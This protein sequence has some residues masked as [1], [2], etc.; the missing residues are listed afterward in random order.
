MEI[1]KIKLNNFRNYTNVE[2]FPSSGTNIFY[3]ENGSGKTNIIEAIY[4]T[5]MTKSFR[6]SEDSF[7]VLENT[8]KIT[9]ELEINFNG[10]HKNISS[11]FLKS[12]KKRI[13]KINNNK[14]KRIS[15]IIGTVPI[16]IFSPESIQMLKSDP[17]SRR[18]F[19]DELLFILNNGYY[20]LIQKY[21][22]IIAHR[23]YL[24]K[25]IKEGKQNR[26]ILEPW[27]LQMIEYGSQIIINRYKII[28][29]LNTTIKNE[30]PEKFN[31]IKLNYIAKFFNEFT[32]DSVKNTF[33]NQIDK[34]INEEIVRSVSLIGPHRDDMDVLF[35]NK[36]AKFYASE[37]Q[38]RII[39]LMLKFAEAILLKK[40]NNNSPIILLDDFS[41]E[42][43]ENNRIN[44][45]NFITSFKQ[46]F[47]T[48]TSLDNLKSIKID[49]KFYIKNGVISEEL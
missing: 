11:E 46:V 13:I 49:K 34:L 31:T 29:E 24:L 32:L 42:L 3:G 2:L 14:L 27:N 44:I 37:G 1:N 15:D 45:G 38:Q 21:Q 18:R 35:F 7:L 17:A 36:S 30:L 28:E 10:V 8:D 33:K 26:N 39:T 23:N 9:V 16:V 20:Q 6:T 4:W 19:L 5:C 48:T 41:S 25:N 22:K 47:I 43:D 40:K 12:Q